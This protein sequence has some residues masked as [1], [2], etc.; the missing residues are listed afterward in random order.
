MY[1]GFRDL[2][3]KFSNIYVVRSRSAPAV[4]PESF[5]PKVR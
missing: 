2:Y 1:F 3:L 4:I 5:A